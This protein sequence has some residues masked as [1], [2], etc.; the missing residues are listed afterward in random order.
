M[1]IQCAQVFRVCGIASFVVFCVL[2]GSYQYYY[3]Y[4]GYYG[5]GALRSSNDIDPGPAPKRWREDLH[6]GQ[7]Y[8]A[9]DGKPAECDPVSAHPCCS[10][11]NLCGDTA[12]HCDCPTCVDYRNPGLPDLV[13]DPYVIQAT[14][15]LDTQPMS[16]LQCALSENCLARS[17][18]NA[19]LNDQ[20]KL[21][22]FALKTEN[23]GKGE[24]TPKLPRRF[25]I[26]HS[27][28]QHFH[29]MD[30]FSFYDLLDNAG[31]QA[32][33]GHKPSWC[34]E[35]TGC[36]DTNSRPVR[37]NCRRGTQ[38]ISGGCWDT[39]TS[40]LDCQWIDVT[41]VKPGIYVM[42]VSVNHHR[43]ISESDYSNNRVRCD[44]ILE[45]AS[46]YVYNC[47][48]TDLRGLGRVYR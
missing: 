5:Y 30:A 22:R 13:P 4:Y 24:F 18:S 31:R 16:K 35:N 39:Y 34:L 28:H 40:D 36:G 12:A 14:A 45:K 6:C 2:Y 10:A 11:G 41:D 19:D 7:Y 15:Y 37:Y 27:C 42:E 17:A 33:E 48:N 25:W 29:S 38:G 32:A 44:V 46:A 23:R 21:L 3:N 20:R 1:Q 26:W 9:Q 8:P 47:A 43:R